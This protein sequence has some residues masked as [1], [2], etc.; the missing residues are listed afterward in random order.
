MTS[1]PS[2]IVIGGGVIGMSIALHLKWQ[3]A[4]VHLIERS[5][6][7]SGVSQGGGGWVAAQGRRNIHQLA[8]ALDSIA[9]YPQ[10]LERIGGDAGFAECGSLLLLETDDHIAARR[11]VLADQMQLPGYD[12]FD[13]LTPADLQKLEPAIRSPHIIAASYRARDCQVDPPALMDA[14]AAAVRRDGITTA[15]G[16]TVEGLARTAA[17]WTVST[18]L[19]DFSSDVVVNAAGYGAPSISAMVGRPLEVNYISGQIMRSPPRPFYVRALIVAAHNHHIPN[20]P[21]RDLRQGADGRIWI[22]TVNHTNTGVEPVVSR[23]DTDLVRA[24]MSRLFPELADLPLER[25]YAGKRPLAADGLPLYGAQGDGM[26]I[27]APMSGIA[28]A[29][30]AGR[31]MAELIT[32]GASPGLPEAF[33]PQRLGA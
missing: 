30:A 20:C 11:D 9:Q 26:Y 28:E 31:T 10:M 22:G 23:A 7:G 6:L 19:G 2:V 13:I 14:M 29:A 24:Q 25:G 8:F 21:A 5:T 16:A 3:G 33:S 4:R 15:E 17:G 18:T 32:T 27:A 1:G 12:G